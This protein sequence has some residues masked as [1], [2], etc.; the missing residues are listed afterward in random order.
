MFKLLNVRRSE[1]MCFRPLRPKKVQGFALVQVA[2]HWPVKGWIQY[3]F[4]REW[5]GCLP[6]PTVGVG[7]IAVD[8]MVFASFST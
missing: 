5:R 2:P 8:W 3:V 1:I 7:P 4:W 6:F